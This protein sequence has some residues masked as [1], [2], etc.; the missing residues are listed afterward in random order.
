MHEH[1]TLMRSYPAGR[2]IPA[3]PDDVVLSCPAKDL[4]QGRSAGE[5]AREWWTRHA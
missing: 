5:R 4:S 2:P 3:A 1:V